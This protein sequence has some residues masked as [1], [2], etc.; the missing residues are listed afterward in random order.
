MKYKIVA[1]GVVMEEG[2]TATK[3]L[4]AVCNIMKSV[5]SGTKIEVFYLSERTGTPVYRLENSFV[6]K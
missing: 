3:A 6:T 1:S 4:N 2:I 5:D